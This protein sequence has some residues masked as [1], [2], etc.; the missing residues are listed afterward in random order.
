MLT[1]R[2]EVPY[3]S[4]YRERPP[5]GEDAVSTL[6][7]FLKSGLGLC[8]IPGYACSYTPLL[9]FLVTGGE[10]SICGLHRAMPSSRT[11]A[12][13]AASEVHRSENRPAGQARPTYHPPR[14]PSSLLCL[15]TVLGGCH[16]VAENLDLHLA[17]PV[18]PTIRYSCL[19]TIKPALTAVV[20]PALLR[21]FLTGAN[22]LLRCSRAWR[23]CAA[24]G[25][26]PTSEARRRVSSNTSRH[27]NRPVVRSSFPRRRPTTKPK[28]RVFELVRHGHTWQEIGEHI[29]APDFELVKRRF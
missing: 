14:R 2:I 22:I 13:T 29:G 4:A 26:Y 11:Q 24:S 10:F 1:G 18:L 27:C 21:S 7:K 25:R 3:L 16:L 19:L 9:M 23:N 5:V 8:P 6:Q 15:R 17:A 12:E 28:D 20:F